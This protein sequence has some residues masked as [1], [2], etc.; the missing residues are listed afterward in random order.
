[1][2]GRSHAG[3]ALSGR[4]PHGEGQMDLQRVVAVAPPRAEQ[5]EIRSMRW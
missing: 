3:A 2:T 5:R 1:M 4:S